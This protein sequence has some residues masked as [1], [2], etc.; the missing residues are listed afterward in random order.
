[1]NRGFKGLLLYYFV[2]FDIQNNWSGGYE[3]RFE[4]PVSFNNLIDL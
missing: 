3:D 4:S 2:Y 1:M